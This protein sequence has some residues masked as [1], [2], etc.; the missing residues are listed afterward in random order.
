MTGTVRDAAGN[1]IT[2]GASVQLFNHTNETL[3]QSTV[4]DGSGNFSFTVGNN[5]P[6]WLKAYL[7]GSPDLAGLTINNVTPSPV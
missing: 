5:S 1:A 4:S 2:T 3:E 6:R 7:V